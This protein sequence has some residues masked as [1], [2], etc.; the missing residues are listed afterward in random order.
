M[1]K[2]EAKLDPTVE[3]APDNPIETFPGPTVGT[4]EAQSI[5]LVFWESIKDSTRLADYVAYLEQYPE[6]KFVTL[7]EA[8]VKESSS[9]SAGMRDPKDRDVELSFW[10]FVRESDNPAT[11][12]A[13]LEKYPDG[14]FKTLAEIRLRE[15]HD[16]NNGQA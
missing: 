11:L 15:L 3:T 5:E 9:T 10:E 13:Y 14:E 2:T 8:R 7:A 4:N 6:G 16:T 1:T 12:E